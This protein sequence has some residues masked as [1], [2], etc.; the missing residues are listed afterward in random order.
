MSSHQIYL[1]VF[2]QR[3]CNM[4]LN[5]WFEL[6]KLNGHLLIFSTFKQIFKNIFVYSV[7]QYFAHQLCYFRISIVIL[8]LHILS[9]ISFYFVLLYFTNVFY[10]VVNAKGQFRT[11]LLYILLLLVFLYNRF[12]LV[13]K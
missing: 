5:H 10:K 11:K 13:F 9:H 3:A 4:P 2:Q 7:S 1:P 12:Y 6:F 8:R